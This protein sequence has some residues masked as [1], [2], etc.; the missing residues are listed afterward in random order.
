MEDVYSINGYSISN[1]LIGRGGVGTVYRGKH[2]ETGGIVAVKMINKIPR[3]VDHKKMD[4]NEIH[5]ITNDF[6]KRILNEVNIHSKLRH[7]SILKM[8][9]F[10]EDSKYFFMVLEFCERGNLYEY[11][12]PHSKRSSEASVRCILD[13]VVKGL[14]Y[15]HS[16]NIIH[17]DVTLNNLLLT[18]SMEV[19]I[20]DF[21]LAVQQDLLD[22]KQFTMCGTPNYMAPEI[23]SKDRTNGHGKESDIWSIGCLMYTLLVGVHPFDG[24]ETKETLE[25]IVHQKLHIPQS[26]SYEAQDL[27]FSLLQKDPLKRPTISQVA[28][29][30]F[31]LGT[32][33]ATNSMRQSKQQIM[34]GPLISID[35][36]R[37]T[38]SSQPSN[39]GYTRPLKATQHHSHDILVDRANTS[40]KLLHDDRGKSRSLNNITDVRS[41]GEA[42]STLESSCTT[43]ALVDD[44]ISPFDTHRIKSISHETRTS[45]VQIT[46]TGH[47]I[48]RSK[49]K[50]K[51]IFEVSPDGQKINIYYPHD[52]DMWSHDQTCDGPYAGYRLYSSHTYTNLPSRYQKKYRYA[53]QFVEL[54]KSKTP[55]VIYRD[56]KGKY[57]L[58]EN[59]EFE[60]SYFDGTKLHIGKGVVKCTGPTANGTYKISD[61]MPDNVYQLYQSFLENSDVLQAFNSFLM[62]CQFK[63][64]IYPVIVGHSTA[65]RRRSSSVQASPTTNPTS[66]VIFDTKNLQNKENDS[67]LGTT[68]CSNYS[69]DEQSKD[70]RIIKSV[71][72]KEIGQV[73]KVRRIIALFGQIE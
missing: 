68:L 36:G 9:D 66:S 45:T 60:V 67:L 26:L 70:D 71:Y 65:E 16:Y 46:D 23:A 64:N 39:S 19:K 55:K 57:K 6:R 10:F 59:G 29:H 50:K 69:R 12:K 33:M 15:L 52:G 44:R 42:S 37:Y 27:L 22:Q 8:Y 34:H 41:R 58:M 49:F 38:S 17:R 73:M 3:V 7:N 32:K 61:P 63:Q 18:K 24:S 53:S 62:Q 40:Y 13:S 21:G 2:N 35:S 28:K 48:I 5:S 11:L 14:S 4:P 72:D 43:Q 56:D 25:K 1:V 30:P 47:F 54:V 31:M 20:A 51:G